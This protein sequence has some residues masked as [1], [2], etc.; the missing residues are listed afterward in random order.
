MLIE[1]LVRDFG[2]I[3]EPRCSGQVE[4]RLPNVL[5]IAPSAVIACAESWDYIVVCSRSK[6]AC[7]TTSLELPNRFPCTT[8]CCAYSW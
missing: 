1:N 3:V 4:H 5:V 6:L 8:H 2:A 7:L